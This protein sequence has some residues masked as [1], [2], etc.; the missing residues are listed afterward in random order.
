MFMVCSV[1]ACGSTANARPR[2]RGTAPFDNSKSVR[3]GPDAAG[4]VA[5]GGDA[6]EFGLL[7]RGHLRLLACLVA[8]IQHLDLLEILEGLAERGLRVIELSLQFGGGAMEVLAAG[9]RR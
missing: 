3:S 1:K 9:D 2:R 4:R 5:D 6:V 8:L 7:A